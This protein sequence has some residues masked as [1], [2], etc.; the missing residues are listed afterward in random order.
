M[1]FIDNVTST[2]HVL[3]LGES[4]AEYAPDGCTTIGVNDIHS[5][6][7]TDYV[8]C[9]DHPK[10][11]TAERQRTILQTDCKVFFSHVKEWNSVRNFRM[12]DI[13]PGRANLLHLHGDKIVCG[14]SSPYVAA[15]IAY[16]S[17][18]KRI[19]LHGCDYRTH[20]N[21]KSSS[22]DQVRNHFHELSRK[23]SERNVQLFV[24]SNYST[25]SDFLPLWK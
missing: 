13:A 20:P 5:R 23:F 9:V 15:V 4:L 8:V 25:L 11:F 12:I 19:V 17:G 1:E 16:R 3:G 24:G 7:Q 21:F 18:A 10:A 6:V 2:V 14:T 22:L